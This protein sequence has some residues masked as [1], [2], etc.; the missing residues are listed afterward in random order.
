[1]PEEFDAESLSLKAWMLLHRTRDLFFRCE[2]QVVAGFGL[3]AEQ[4]SVLLAIEYLDAPVRATDVGRW[5]ERKV[6]SVSMIVDRM[7]KAGLVTRER[8][9]PDRRAVRLVI[10]GKGDRAFKAATPA[11]WR[12]IEEIMSQLSN[13][14]SLTLVRLLQTLREKALQCLNPKDD[15]QEMKSYD[16]EDMVRFIERMTRYISR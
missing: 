1:M 5:L 10:T 12:L 16:T 2:D 11:V 15:P 3:T 4:Y 14:D 13:E 6:N 7:V 9:L 8:D